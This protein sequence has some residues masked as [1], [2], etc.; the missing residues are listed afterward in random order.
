MRYQPSPNAAALSRPPPIAGADG[1]ALEPDFADLTG[2]D[3]L[4]VAHQPHRGE[5]RRQSDR[6]AAV[7]HRVAIDGHVEMAV[8][9]FRLVHRHRPACRLPGSA[10]ARAPARA[11]APP[12]MPMAWTR[13]SRGREIVVRRFGHL[14]HRPRC[15]SDLQPSAPH[16]CRNAICM[17]HIRNGKIKCNDNRRRQPC[18]CA[19]HHVRYWATR[20][21][22]GVSPAH[23][24]LA[25]LCDFARAT[26]ASMASQKLFG[27][28]DLAGLGRVADRSCQWA[29]C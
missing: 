25:A 6:A 12:T 7:A 1:L 5:R 28:G 16:D 8:T 17:S 27:A 24:D 22:I 15:T 29:R 2:G 3:I 13:A 11:G 14:G 21:F 23:G 9:T 10:W 19:H 4:P 26:V 20:R 18:R